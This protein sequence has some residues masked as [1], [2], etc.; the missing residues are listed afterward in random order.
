M[1]KRK[2][3]E[4]EIEESILSKN[5]ETF[6]DATVNKK[7]KINNFHLRLLD[8]NKLLFE[9][10]INKKQY[11]NI[12]F[13]EC[14]V[15]IFDFILACDDVNTFKEFLNDQEFCFYSI[16][17]HNACHC[18][19]YYIKVKTF[20]YPSALR[21]IIEHECNQNI[22]QIIINNCPN[23]NQLLKAIPQKKTYLNL[24]IENQNLNFIKHLIN[25]GAK[26]W[27]A[28]EIIKTNL[29]QNFLISITKSI[30][31]IEACEKLSVTPKQELRSSCKTKKSDFSFFFLQLWYDLNYTQIIIED[32][33]FIPPI[34]LIVKDYL[35]IEKKC[36]I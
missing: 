7:L 33:N 34:Q 14:E 22:I 3:T 5:T 18:L 10:I 23:L 21:Y 15:D 8:E 13:D 24:A 12:V 17:Y 26:F 6:Y 11:K 1:L 27:N 9:W 20:D 35:Y 19:E 28:N 25:K 2:I 36:Q 4:D 32:W 29:E 16:L 30:N 31:W